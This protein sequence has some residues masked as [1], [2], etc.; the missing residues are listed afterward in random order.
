MKLSTLPDEE[1]L[2]VADP[3]MDNLMQGSKDIDH[4]RHTR[5]FTERLAKIV[6][7][8][9]LEEMCRDYQARIGY[10]TEREFVAIFRRANSVAVVWRQWSSKTTDE[11]VA[12]IVIV[13]RN[14]R[15]LVDHA[16]V[17]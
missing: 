7:A 1:I 14:G 11:F 6:T 3:L 10:F 8:E 4:A 9:R 12:E 13:E 5:D 2:A 16:Q 15:H 17:Y